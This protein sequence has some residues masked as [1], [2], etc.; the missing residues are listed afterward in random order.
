MDGE[1]VMVPAVHEYDRQQVQVF[2]SLCYHTCIEA[3]E[4]I[5]NPARRLGSCHATGS[6]G[7]MT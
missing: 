1:L 2:S 5:Y 3:R 4:V 6:P 7:R